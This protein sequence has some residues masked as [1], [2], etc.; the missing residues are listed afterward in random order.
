MK[1]IQNFLFLVSYITVNLFFGFNS[2]IA[3]EKAVPGVQY[4]IVNFASAPTTATVTKTVLRYNKDFA[5]SFHTDDGFADVYTVGFP[6]LQASTRL[7]QTI[8]ACFILMGVEMIF[9]L[10]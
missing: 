9:H 7:A 2:L 8:L 6:F 10:N 4:V 5:F 3:Q 1:N